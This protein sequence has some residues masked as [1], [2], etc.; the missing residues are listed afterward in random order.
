MTPVGIDKI[1]FFVPEFYIDMTDLALARDVDPAK[2]HQGIGQDQMAVNPVTQDII[3]FATSAAQ[4]ILT[5]QDKE[6]IDMVILATET[7]TDESKAGAIII[8]G[9]L[10]IQ[11]F[12]RSIEM[13]EA[14]YAGTA[15]IQMAKDYVRQH[16]YRKVLVIA[17]DI[18]KYGLGSAGEPTQGAGAVAMLISENPSILELNDDVLSFSQDVYDFWRPTGQPYPSVDGKFS[19]ETYIN[20]FA[21]L[22]DEYTSRTGREFK[23]FSALTFHTPYT[24]MGKKALLPK[25]ENED[26]LV[27]KQLLEQYEHSITYSRRVGNLYTGSLYLGLIS[28]LE[29]SNQLKSGDLIGLFSYGSG[30]VGEFFSGTL[31]EGYEK[32]LRK[33]QHTALLDKRKNLTIPEYEEMFNQILDLSLNQTFDDSA[34]F[35]ISEISN[36]H[37]IYKK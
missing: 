24:K 18:A 12:A 11:P 5:E 26:D 31:V 25:L 34:S 10:D 36:N 3:T 35:S 16:P 37:R 7:S 6:L 27:Q 17:S 29:N 28:L 30:T 32:S 20:T 14:C 23:D 19:N 22:W 13:K 8:H 1:S 33:V 4:A 2:F 15:G 21:T 9:L